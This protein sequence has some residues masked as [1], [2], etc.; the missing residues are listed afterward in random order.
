MNITRRNFFKTIAAGALFG[1]SLLSESLGKVSLDTFMGQ[2][3]RHVADLTTLKRRLVPS[4]AFLE[5]ALGLNMNVGAG[6]SLSVRNDLCERGCELKANPKTLLFFGQISD[7]HVL[8]EESPARLVAAEEYLEKLGVHSAFRP[9]DDLTPHVLNSMVE[10]MNE[11]AKRTPVD[12]LLNTGDSLDNAQQNELSWFISTLEGGEVD[13]DSGL[14]EDPLFGPNN[15]A[16]DPFVSRGLLAHIPWY[17]AFGNHDF[18]LQGNIPFHLLSLY[19]SIFEKIFDKLVIQNPVGDFSN[20]VLKPWTTPPNL[21]QLKP[22]KIIA[23]V[24]R[25]ALGAKEYLKMHWQKQSTRPVLGFPRNLSNSEFLYYSVYPKAGLPLKMIVLDTAS[26]SGTA[27][28]TIDE[29]QYKKFLIPELEKAKANKELVMIV[30]HHPGDDIKTLSGLREEM[31]NT[32]GREKSLAEGIKEFFSQ[33]EVNQNY[34]S[35]EQFQE[36]LKSYP[37]VFLHVAG[38]R[39]SHKVT[40]IGSS[41]QGYWEVQSASLLD[42]PQQSRLFEIVYEGNNTGAIH[43]CVVDH[44]SPS[45]SLSAYS[46][47]LAYQDATSRAPQ[48]DFKDY[49]GKE[50]DRNTILRF[51]I[52]PEIAKKL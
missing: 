14:N 50:A 40:C 25:S 37:N 41:S 11:I 9:Q 22:G 20:A 47:Q 23:D 39:H 21:S 36:T 32:Y 10:S 16:N 5:K 51:S 4:L 26:R 3:L 46:R 38:H 13:A 27:L 24:Q 6:E 18:L 29:V 1:Q 45:G 31:Y 49:T 33:I 19:N 12:F 15:D 28:G 2:S 7:A 17:S 34:I 48:S 52:P 42:Y 44:N 35:R 8:D 30:S 43:T